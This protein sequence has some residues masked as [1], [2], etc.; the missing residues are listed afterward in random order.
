MIKKEKLQIEIGKWKCSK[1]NSKCIICNRSV[2]ALVD[3]QAQYRPDISWLVC[4][5]RANQRCLSMMTSSLRITDRW[6]LR[7]IRRKT[8]SIFPLCMTICSAWKCYQKTRNL[9]CNIRFLVVFLSSRKNFKC[10][11]QRDLQCEV[12]V[13][14]GIIFSLLFSEF[15]LNAWRGIYLLKTTS[16]LMF[17]IFSGL[18]IMSNKSLIKL[19]H[20]SICTSNGDTHKIS[21][22][23]SIKLKERCAS[24]LVYHCEIW[25]ILFPILW[26]LWP[27]NWWLFLPL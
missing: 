18:E 9:C 3:P 15:T 1:L 22:R 16:E 25:F 8:R 7:Q 24:C 11:E 14:R 5:S 4:L 23:L 12:A 2:L 26:L 13:E 19:I 10:L 27:R 20:S 17:T 6:T 21:A